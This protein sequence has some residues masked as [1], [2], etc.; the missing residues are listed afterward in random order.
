MAATARPSRAR[1]WQSLPIPNPEGAPSLQVTARQ[2]PPDMY[3][4]AKPPS[5]SAQAWRS[6]SPPAQVTTAQSPRASLQAPPSRRQSPVAVQA[7]VAPSQT[8]GSRQAP[9]KQPAQ[10]APAAQEAHASP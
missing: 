7:S 1:A 6:A 8:A 3:E 9:P 5:A 2:R 10:A 4:V